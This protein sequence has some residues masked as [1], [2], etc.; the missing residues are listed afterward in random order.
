MTE[1]GRV[2]D[3]ISDMHQ[4]FYRK[5]AALVGDPDHLVSLVQFLTDIDMEVLYVVTGTPAGPK[6]ERQIKDLAGEKT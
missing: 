6:F 4:Y 3:T 5:K 2:I 1:R